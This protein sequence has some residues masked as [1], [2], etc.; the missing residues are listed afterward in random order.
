[1]ENPIETGPLTIWELKAA[2]GATKNGRRGGPSGMIIEQ[3]KALPDRVL[4]ELLAFSSAAMI[5]LLSLRSG[6]R[7]RWWASSRKV[8]TT[9]QKTTDQLACWK[10]ATSCSPGFWP[11]ACNGPLGP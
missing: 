3:I 9:S 8:P 2:I 11:P 7:R 4:S 5:P 10:R 6:R 1:M